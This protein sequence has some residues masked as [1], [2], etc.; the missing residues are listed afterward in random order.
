MQT[1]KKIEVIVTYEEIAKMHSPEVYIMSKL[2]NAG[3]PITGFFSASDLVSS[4]V[5]RKV[6]H[7]LEKF[8]VYTWGV[9]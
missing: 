3:I 6:E 2:R 4:G 1:N 9:V 8:I 7:K 5:L